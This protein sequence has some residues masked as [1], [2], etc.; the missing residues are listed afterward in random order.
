MSMSKPASPRSAS[1]AMSILAERDCSAMYSDR[2]RDDI[3]ESIRANECEQRVV[4]TVI[5]TCR[6]APRLAPLAPKAAPATLP[7][8][9]EG[10]YALDAEGVVKFYKVD[11]PEK[12]K[13][14]GWVFVK[15]L[16]S[17][18]EYPIRNNA[19]KARILG[20]IAAD[21]QGAFARYGLE[22]GACGVCN[23]TL[24]DE[25]SRARG[26]GPVCMEKMGF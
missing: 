3:M 7:D 22:I 11:R 26:I 5:D 15:A 14:A 1:W 18:N 2:Q 24:T 8:V 6:N 12:G 25:D 10:R 9:P 23:R 17:D 4:S 19:E 21:V 20:E 16:A 13:W